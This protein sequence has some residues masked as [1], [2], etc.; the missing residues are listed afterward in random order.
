MAKSKGQR[1]LSETLTCRGIYDTFFLRA[2]YFPTT[3]GAQDAVERM[4][5]GYGGSFLKIMRGYKVELTLYNDS[6]LPALCALAV[7]SSLTIRAWLASLADYN[8]RSLRRYIYTQDPR[9]LTLLTI[10]NG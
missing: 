2:M 10:P 3:Y 5:N 6:L 7:R 9:R 8:E 1:E 4:G